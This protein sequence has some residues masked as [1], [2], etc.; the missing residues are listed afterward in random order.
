MQRDSRLDRTQEPLYT[1]EHYL[2]WF[3]GAVAV[4]LGII[5]ILVGFGILDFR[6]ADTVVDINGVTGKQLLGRHNVAVLRDNRG[7]RNPL[8]PR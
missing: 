6:S 8:P 5:G 1:T 3:M 4:V 7:N 2:A